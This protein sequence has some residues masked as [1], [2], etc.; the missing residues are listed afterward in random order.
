MIGRKKKK[1][2]DE[3]VLNE[4]VV[5]AYLPVH[6]QGL[7]TFVPGSYSLLDESYIRDCYEDAEKRLR[8]IIETTDGYT[9]GT[10]CDE[11][12]DGQMEHIDAVFIKE[13][14]KKTVQCNRINASKKTRYDELIRN[15]LTLEDRNKELKAWIEPLKGLH[16]QHELT[17][18]PVNIP[19]GTIVTGAAMIIDGMVNYSYLESILLQSLFLLIICVL[20]L[21]VLSDGCMWCLGNL[22]S[23]R[24]EETM[25]RSTYRILC[26][27]F[28]S[29]FIL[30]VIASLMIRF[31]SMASTYGTINAEGQFVGKD[32][33]T[34]AEWGVS[35]V[36]AFLTTATGLISFYYSIDKNAHL[37]GRRRAYEKELASSQKR[38]EAVL[39][40]VSALENA[41]DPNIINRAYK[42]AAEKNKEALHINL[43]LHARYL[44]DLHQQDSSYTD[45]MSE[46]GAKLLK[47]RMD[48]ENWD[49]SKEG[50]SYKDLSQEVIHGVSAGNIDDQVRT[51]DLARNREDSG[52][53]GG[54]EQT[55]G[56]EG[57]RADVIP[58]AK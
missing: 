18:G 17:V 51:A 44:L 50:S 4:V 15:K 2:G 11:Q 16:A 31:G 35:L 21:S 20:C 40:E 23:R 26:A 58:F 6:G 32:S 30:S 27:G 45:A 25:D 48:G 37:V 46:S 29:L 43:Q 34:L 24:E 12:I 8:P 22:I 42:K 5:P 54:E 1:I 33:Y 28:L 38:L 14:A 9:P 13:Y 53:A 55:E 47:D 3:T 7:D 39:L 36:T 57:F 49:R 19:T 10:V 52:N 56:A 41:I